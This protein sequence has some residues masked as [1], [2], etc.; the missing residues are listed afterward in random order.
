MYAT[1]C[2]ILPITFFFEKHHKLLD[3]VEEEFRI[4]GQFLH[5]L[6]VKWCGTKW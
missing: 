6:F 1:V 4:G 2:R 5:F 3:E